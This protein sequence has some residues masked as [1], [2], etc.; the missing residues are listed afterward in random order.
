MAPA[1]RFRDGL[2]EGFGATRKGGAKGQNTWNESDQWPTQ[3][4][5]LE[6]SSTAQY[7]NWPQPAKGKGYGKPK[8]DPSTLWC[9]IHQT[10][11]RSTDWCF[12]NPYRTGGPPLANSRLWCNSC[13]SYGRTSNTCYANSPRPTHKGKGKPPHSKGKGGKGQ[14]GDRKWKS[15]NFPAAYNPEQ[16]TP[17]LHDESPSKDTAQ[18]WWGTSELG[19]SCLDRG[20]H[21]DD[22]D[23]EYDDA[24]IAEEIDLHFLA[25]IKNIER[26]NEYFLAPT[27]EKLLEFNEHEGYITRATSQLN[28]HSQRI[29]FRFQEEIGYVGCMD[30]FIANKHSLE[31]VKPDRGLYMSEETKPTLDMSLNTQFEHE[32]ESRTRNGIGHEI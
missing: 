13:N 15:Q 19:S 20:E 12:D 27:A 23:S 7:V 32:M 21:K 26:Q 6:A 29:V 28:I 30:T 1:N 3:W 5:S 9:D 25:I 10:S 22:S 24:E 17:A 4:S 11:G 2:F 16:A 18:E 8:V 31:K 14:F